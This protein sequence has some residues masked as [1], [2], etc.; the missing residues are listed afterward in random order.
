MRNIIRCSVSAPSLSSHA[1]HAQHP[2]ILA[3]HA[4][5]ATATVCKHVPTC[6]RP[7]NAAIRAACRPLPGGQPSIPACWSCL[8]QQTVTQAAAAPNSHQGA[9]AVPPSRLAHWPHHA[10]DAGQ[11]RQVHAHYLLQL[12][13]TKPHPPP[14]LGCLACLAPG[15]MT[16]MLCWLTAAIAV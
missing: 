11:P 7:S 16:T 8:P 2:S 9:Q 3:M 1:C 10:G 6:S 12:Y 5:H 15:A 4:R 13:P 14:C